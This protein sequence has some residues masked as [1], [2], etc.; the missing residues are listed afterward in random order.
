M[1]TSLPWTRHDALTVAKF[2][3][4]S[5][6]WWACNEANPHLDSCRSAPRIWLSDGLWSCQ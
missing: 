1:E 6:V 4:F 3:I 5:W 2:W